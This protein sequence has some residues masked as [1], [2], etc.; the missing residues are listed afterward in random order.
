MVGGG[1]AVAQEESGE[2]HD[3]N[4]GAEPKQ[5][6]PVGAELCTH[7]VQVNAVVV[8]LWCLHVPVARKEG[9]HARWRGSFVLGEGEEE[10]VPA[11]VSAGDGVAIDA[12]AGDPEGHGAAARGGGGPLDDPH[13]VG[14]VG[15]GFDLR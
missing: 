5:A 4:H 1:E 15:A 2:D 12:V 3:D 9:A 10:L 8:R 14:H 13:A 11:V 6:E 7:V